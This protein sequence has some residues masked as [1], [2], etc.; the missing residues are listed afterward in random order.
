MGKKLDLN[1]PKTLTEKI[2]W[3]KLFQMSSLT[4][5]LADKREVRTW[6]EDQVGAQYLIPLLGVWDQA[7][8]I[9]LDCLPDRF[10]LKC[11][12]GSGFNVVVKCKNDVDWKRLCVQLDDWLQIN[13]AFVGGLEMQYRDI[14]PRI[15]AEQYI[16]N[17][18]L[19]LNDYKVW[20]FNGQPEYV[21]YVSGHADGAQR[22]FYDA[23]WRKQSFSFLG[24]PDGGEIRRPDKLNEMLDLA[25]RLSHGFALVRVDLY[26]L[27]DGGIKFGEMTFTPNSGVMKIVPQQYDLYL[28]SMLQLPQVVKET[29][30]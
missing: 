25:R 22:S 6:I 8:D 13:F 23:Q 11:T 9:D 7:N 14:R 18:G 27:D 24:M 21:Q 19:E 29:T 28:G 12:H 5:M 1:N 16:D 30:A 4:T 17:H 20:C 15:I 26:V 2:Q 3:L 10:V